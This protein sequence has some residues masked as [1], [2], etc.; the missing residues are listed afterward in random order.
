V[1]K[2]KNLIRSINKI[3]IAVPSVRG[4]TAYWVNG[5]VQVTQVLGSGAGMCPPSVKI[6]FEWV[7]FTSVAQITC[8]LPQDTQN[9]F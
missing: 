9:P 8:I 6:I 2:R 3:M 1:K 4:P 5:F 7:G